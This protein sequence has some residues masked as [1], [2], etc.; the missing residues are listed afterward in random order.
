MYSVTKAGLDEL[1][2]V[3]ASELGPFGIRVNAIRPGWVA[4]E[5]VAATTTPENMAIIAEGT[6]LAHLSAARW[7]RP[8][9]GHRPR[10]RLLRVRLLGLG[11][12]PDAVGLRRFVAAP[13]IGRLRLHRQ[14]DVPRRDGARLPGRRLMAK[15]AD[16]A[17]DADEIVAA[18]VDIFEEQGLDAVSMR[19]VSARLGVSPVPL[20]SRVG[21]QGGADRRDRR[22]PP[23]R[24]RAAAWTTARRGRR[25]RAR[26]A[27]RL[28]DRL[29]PGAR[30][31]ADPDGRAA[32]RTSRRRVRWSRRCATTAS[33]PTPRC[34]RAGCSCGRRSASSRSRRG[35]EPPPSARSGRR[36]RSGGD[37]AG[38]TPAEADELF[39]LHDPLRDRRHRPRCRPGAQSTTT[40]RGTKR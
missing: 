31:P 37:P 8:A 11:D 32:R 1:V 6:P 19:S 13:P 14:D 22:P 17:L 28:R 9:G 20:Y 16:F 30:Q 15:P 34:R 39:A 18:A 36:R 26:W 10:R 12:R 38:V 5:T 2:R 4:T 24:P 7:P 23:H 27:Q 21:Q 40:K 25:T 35:A 3:S 29:R 33:P